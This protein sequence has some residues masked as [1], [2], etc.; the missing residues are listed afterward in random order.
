MLVLFNL[1]ENPFLVSQRNQVFAW[2]EPDFPVN[3][4]YELCLFLVL[5][6]A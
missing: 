2:L 4:V 6:D 3:F 1:E 5:F